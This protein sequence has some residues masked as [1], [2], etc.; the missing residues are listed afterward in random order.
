MLAQ[1]LVTALVMGM[2]GT[3]A[4]MDNMADTANNPSWVRNTVV[5]WGVR[6]R[7]TAHCF[8]R[9]SCLI[10]GKAGKAPRQKAAIEIAK[11]IAN[12]K[13]QKAKRWNLRS[14]DV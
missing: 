6:I 9:F 1:D 13:A 7:K 4:V 10:D 12:R 11:Q 3:A 14:E 8:S 2:G 5:V